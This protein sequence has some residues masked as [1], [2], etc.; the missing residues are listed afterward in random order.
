MR[1]NDVKL[2]QEVFW[3]LLDKLDNKYMLLENEL[4]KIKY[5]KGEKI[6][7]AILNKI[8]S[9]EDTVSEK[10]YFE[11]LNGN[12]VIIIST[13]YISQIILKLTTCILHS[14]IFLI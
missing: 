11:I 13:T 12:D 1:I 5:F 7:L 2:D 6:N 14:N 8:I 3:K 9:R 10:I 4:D